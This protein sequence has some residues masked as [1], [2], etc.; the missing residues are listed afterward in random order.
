[1]VHIFSNSTQ[2]VEEGGFLWIQGYTGLHSE[3]Q[4]SQDCSE[5]LSQKIKVYF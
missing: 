2:E 1:M 5:I 4:A 3:L